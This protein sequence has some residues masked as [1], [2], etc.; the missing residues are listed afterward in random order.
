MPD[1]VDEDRDGSNNS[2]WENNNLKSADNVLFVTKDIPGR[3]K[4]L[5]AAIKISA[6]TQVLAETPI[7]KL[8]VELDDETEIE[9]VVKA[10]QHLTVRNQE[11]F[12][13][14]SKFASDVYQSQPIWGSLSD[15]HKQV[16][17][18]WGAN[19]WNDMVFETGCRIN[20]ACVPNLA[21]SWN[22]R[23]GKQ[24]WVARRDIEVGE[25]LTGTYIYDIGKFR[26]GKSSEDARIKR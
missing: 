11:A 14:L 24:E 21:T 17:A 16:I 9:E 23:S 8:S 26:I 5:V 6:Q 10:F 25:E 18:A 2:L 20:H 1:P 15:E 13:S 7:L 22:E 4:G 3:G 12:L 19:N